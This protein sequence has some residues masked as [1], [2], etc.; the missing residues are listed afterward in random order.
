V[1]QREAPGIAEAMRAASL[2]QTPLAMLS[3][4]VVGVRGRTL[5][6]NL[7]GSPKAVRECL[8]VIVPVLQHAVELV[9]G[10]ASRHQTAS[11]ERPSA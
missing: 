6:I 10:E 3:R 1:L 9:A 4:A 8:A 7:P 2:Q 5:I 11:G